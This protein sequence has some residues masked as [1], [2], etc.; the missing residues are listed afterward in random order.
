METIV[1]GV[2]GSANGTRALRWA[3][4]YAGAVEGRVLAVQAWSIS[5][6]AY[7]GPGF[8]AAIDPGEFERL[9]RASLEKTVAEFADATPAG[10]AVE[11]R[12]VQGGAA[13][14]LM[15][16]ARDVNADLLVVGS[17]GRGGFAGLLLGSV[18]ATL[19]HH[20]PCPLA[21]IPPASRGV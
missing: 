18:S 8:V 17:R 9:A 21:I 1:V 20:T 16:V 11:Q 13:E 6:Y 10:V 3:L 2:D 15:D 5:A 19:A 12:I 4:D 14:A 7:G